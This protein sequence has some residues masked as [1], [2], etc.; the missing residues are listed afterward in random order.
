MRLPEGGSN[1]KN[2]YRMDS[3][4]KP[5]FYQLQ[6]HLLTLCVQKSYQAYSVCLFFPATCTKLLLQM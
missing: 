3:Y 2:M 5:C 4:F 1:D 6:Q